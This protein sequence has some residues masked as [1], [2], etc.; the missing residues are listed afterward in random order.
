MLVRA[1]HR[2]VYANGPFEFSCNVRSGLQ[3]REEVLP[4]TVAAPTNEA[5]VASLP[6]T[7]ALGHLTPRST[8]SQSPE[9]TVDD[10]TVILPLPSSTAAFRQQRLYPPPGVVR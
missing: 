1:G 3:V 7:V 4:G 9:D 5:V 10:P 6:G 8:G 2:A